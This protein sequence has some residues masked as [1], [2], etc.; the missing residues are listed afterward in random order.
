MT[1]ETKPCYFCGGPIPADQITDQHY[2]WCDCAN[3]LKRRNAELEL[4]NKRL[5]LKIPSIN[6][7]PPNNSRDVLIIFYDDI[8]KRGWYDGIN[9]QWYEYGKDLFLYTEVCE[10]VMTWRELR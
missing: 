3:F 4:E 10:K 9:D 7:N 6:N 8:E 2:F 5:K 1:Q